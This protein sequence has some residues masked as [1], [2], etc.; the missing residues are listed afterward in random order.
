[1]SYFAVKHA[2]ML[3]AIISIGL[4][5]FRTILLVRDSDLINAKWVK[6]TP[7]VVDTFLLVSAVILMTIIHQYPIQAPWLTE[8][9]L[10]VFAYI[11]LGVYTIKIAKSNTHRLAG[12]AAGLFCIASVIHLAMAKQSF[13]L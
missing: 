12:L 11:A 2:H 13:V 5:V 10:L 4:L 9:L 3:L 8:K 7:H 6:I 1:M